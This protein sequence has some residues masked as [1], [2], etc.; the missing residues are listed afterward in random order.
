M[1]DKKILEKAIQ[2][3]I[4][5][6]WGLPDYGMAYNF[7]PKYNHREF[8]TNADFIFQHDFAKAL[9]GEAEYEPDCLCGYPKVTEPHSIL[10]GNVHGYW[11]KKY[12]Y[13]HH[14]QQ[15]VIA[16]DPIA[17]LGENI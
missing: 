15:M 1:S 8:Y 3:A 4:D 16:D 7:S 17:Y 9:W 5:G 6:G 2:K 12:G 11:A 13:E 10:D 14:L